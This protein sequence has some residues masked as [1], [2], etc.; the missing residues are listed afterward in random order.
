MP[1]VCGCFGYYVGNQQ[2]FPQQG[3]TISVQ[4]FSSDSFRHHLG[5]RLT[6]AVAKE[7]E[8]RSPYKIVAAGEADSFLSGHLLGDTRRGL[9]ETRNDDL[10]DVE[11]N[12]Y[13]QMQWITRGGQ[14]IRQGEPIVLAPVLVNLSQ[15][16]HVVPEVGQSLATAQQE[17]IERL[18]R[19]IVDQMEV[20]W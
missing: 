11:V 8:N 7:I 17:A 9:V 20:P 4:M 3:R 15:T 1:A 18:A 13:V 16:G 19:Q 12:L 14:V 2:L 10:R 5:E 6:E